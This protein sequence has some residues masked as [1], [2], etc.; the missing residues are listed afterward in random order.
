MKRRIAY[1]EI[2]THAEIAARMVE[3]LGNSNLVETDFFFSPKINGQIPNGEPST[4]V[5]S[6]KILLPSL[7]K[8]DYELVIIGT[9]H[10]YYQ[11]WKKVA[12]KFKIAIII[13][14]KNYTKLSAA[15]R[16]SKIFK[17]DTLYRLKL[18]LWED[19]AH[20]SQLFARTQHLLVLD[21]SL[22][23][24]RFRFFPVFFQ[25]YVSAA[26]SA[27]L[28]VVIPGSVDEHRRDYDHIFNILNSKTFSQHIKFVFLGKSGKGMVHRLEHLKNTGVHH[29]F[30]VQYY[31]TKV[32]AL[33]FDQVM[34]EADVLW[35]P[36]QKITQFFSTDEFYGKT[37][38][39]GNIGD[40]ITFSKPA[41]FP[42]WY[43]TEYPFIFQETGNLEKQVMMV[44]KSRVDWSAYQ[45][46]NVRAN[47]E[48]E[49]I[50]MIN[51]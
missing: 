45:V 37:K 41:I 14:N 42:S 20:A 49:I 25:N 6:P 38:M 13:H 23:D 27:Q 8:R 33:E 2:D 24:H 36:L 32:P 7:E 34:R 10:R 17:Q 16:L 1:V 9:A 31:N 48:T 4:I 30:S 51:C 21:E 50:R 29:N 5:T 22:A 43:D 40:A 12:E 44:A 18:L 3:L 46:E 47:L 19:L 26:S 15:G 28:T 35:C 11:I 39:S